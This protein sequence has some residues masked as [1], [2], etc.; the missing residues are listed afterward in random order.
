MSQVPS[1]SIKMW[2]MDLVL[3]QAGKLYPYQKGHPRAPDSLSWGSS[4]RRV[5]KELTLG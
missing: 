2:E 4:Y 5:W 3:S 1:W